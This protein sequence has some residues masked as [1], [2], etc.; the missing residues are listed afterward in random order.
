[1]CCP[2]GSDPTGTSSWEATRS[3]VVPRTREGSFVV[4]RQFR[5]GPSRLLVELPGGQV[6]PG[7]EVLQAGKRELLEETGYEPSSTTYLGSTWLA[8]NFQIQRHFLLAEGCRKVAEP[9]PG[10]EGVHRGCV[11]RGGCV[12]RAHPRRPAHGPGL[13]LPGIGPPR[14]TVPNGLLAPRRS[15][16][17]VRQ[18]D[19]HPRSSRR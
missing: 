4:A 19:D 16:E 9:D 1:M 14:S 3:P 6:D 18:T 8:A 7:E 2:T 15:L 11:A 5:V 13:R 12:H 17:F 10:D